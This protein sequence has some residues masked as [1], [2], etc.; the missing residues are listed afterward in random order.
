LL[1]RR[2]RLLLLASQIGHHAHD[3]RNLDLLLRTVKFNVI[4]D[5]YPGRAIARDEFLS[6]LLSHARYSC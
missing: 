1:D 5:V 3:E 6:T 4:L 2:Q